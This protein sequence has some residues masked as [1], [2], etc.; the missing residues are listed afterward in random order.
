MHCQA[1]CQHQTKINSNLRQTH[2]VMISGIGEL[3]CHGMNAARVVGRE[4]FCMQ[5]GS[6]RLIEYASLG[7]ELATAATLVGLTTT[8]ILFCSHFHQIEGDIA[9]QK[10]SPLVRLGTRRGYEVILLIL[11]PMQFP[12]AKE[13]LTAANPLIVR[14]LW[15]K[16]A[17]RTHW[18]SMVLHATARLAC[19]E[20]GTY[21]SGWPVTPCCFKACLIESA[22]AAG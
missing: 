10:M 14:I 3:A 9:A 15:K 16:V 8:S 12:Q 2:T 18:P 20:P 5:A 6:A 13:D 4:S 19:K 22:H 17:R 7:P 11:F 1:A 21:R